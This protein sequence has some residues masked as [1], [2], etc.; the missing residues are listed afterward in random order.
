MTDGDPQPVWVTIKAAL[1][2]IPAVGAALW[3]ALGGATNALVIRVTAIEAIRHIVIGAV[4]A[5]G[6][7]GLAGPIMSHWLGLPPEAVRDASG[8]LAAGGTAAYLA[9]SLGAAIFEVLLTRIRAGR[10]PDDPA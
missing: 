1:L 6:L 8:A 5:A 2:A 4:I 9:G 10:L 7:G 3:G